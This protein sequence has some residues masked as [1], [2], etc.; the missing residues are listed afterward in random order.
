MSKY[1]LVIVSVKNISEYAKHFFQ[2]I[3][4]IILCS[5]F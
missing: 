3:L 5:N 1:E 4:T 2:I